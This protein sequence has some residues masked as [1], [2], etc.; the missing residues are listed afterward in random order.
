MGQIDTYAL[1]STAIPPG[2]TINSVKVS[3]WFAVTQVG[4]WYRIVLRTHGVNYTSPQQNPIVTTWQF[5]EHTW[6]NN[7]N[8]G[9]PWTIAELNALEIGPELQSKRSG[10]WTWPTYCTQIYATIDYD[11][12]QPLGIINRFNRKIGALYGH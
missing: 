5:H 11:P 9:N 3:G 2:S 12:P 4:G 10:P 7:P 8:T 6:V 1:P